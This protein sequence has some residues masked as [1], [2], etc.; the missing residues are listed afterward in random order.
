MAQ[1]LNRNL[2]NEIETVT[3]TPDIETIASRRSVYQDQFDEA[4]LNNFLQNQIA[5]RRYSLR[6]F[7]ITSGWL[8]SVVGI[9]LLV[10]FKVL[11]LSDSVLIAL[12]GTTT[13]NVLGF[14]II[15]IQYLFN[16][17]KST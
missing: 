1:D 6:I 10:G 2:I 11:D 3:G 17:D 8:I 9:L 13:V 16:K 4:T 12:L 15:V 7:I 5:R 14:F